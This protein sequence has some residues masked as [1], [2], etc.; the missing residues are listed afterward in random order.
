MRFY[1]KYGNKPTVVDGIKFDSKKEAAYYTDNLLPRKASGQIE[2]INLQVRYIL[3]DGFK[4]NGVYFR[5]IT[6]IADFVLTKRTGGVEVIDVK[7]MKTE[8][9][10]LKRK[11]F[12]KKYPDLT[13]KEV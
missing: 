12:E 9:Y 2:S 10:K 6:Y 1:R 8:V 5:P 4:K 11:L 3:Q 7:G 13:I